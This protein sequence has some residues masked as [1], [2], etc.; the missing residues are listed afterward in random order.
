MDLK[1]HIDAVRREGGLLADSVADLEAAVPTCPGWTVRDLVRH[2][3]EVHRWAP[4]WLRRPPPEPDR[5][6][7]A[8]FIRAACG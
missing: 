4:V 1:T 2:Q 3:G 8:L 5:Q 6:R 7:P